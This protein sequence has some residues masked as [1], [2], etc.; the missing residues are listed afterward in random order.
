[1]NV[2]VFGSFRTG[3][4]LSSSDIDLVVFGKWPQLPLH[5]IADACVQAK[6]CRF[7]DVKVVDKA[8]VPLLKLTMLESGAKVKRNTYRLEVSS[9]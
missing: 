9:G 6:L 1:M 4:Y 7:A 8:F 3:L 2:Q 5:T